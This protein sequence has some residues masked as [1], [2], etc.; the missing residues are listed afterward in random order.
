MALGSTS[1]TGYSRNSK[2]P[3]YAR[4]TA[5]RPVIS[6]LLAQLRTTLP[7]VRRHPPGPR[8]P[9]LPATFPLTG[10]P[11]WR[12]PYVRCLRVRDRFKEG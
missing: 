9:A 6:A 7:Q 2:S 4:N 12:Y 8:P 3:P 10:L 1:G 11:R 5:T